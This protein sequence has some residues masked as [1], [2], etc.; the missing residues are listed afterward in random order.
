MRP[1]H[2]LPTRSAIYKTRQAGPVQ[3]GSTGCDGDEQYYEYHGGVDKALLHYDQSHYAPW[4]SELPGSAHLFNVGGFGENFVSEGYD[5][6][7]VCIG[8]VVNVGREVVVQVSEPRQPCYK[9][10]HRF[11]VKDMSR[12]AQST[13]RTGWYYRVLREGSVQE[14]DE[15]VLV[16]RKH[17]KWS[18]SMVQHFLYADP[19]NAEALQELSELEELGEETRGIFA[20]RLRKQYLDE[21][22]RLVGGE[23]MILSSWKQYRVT[24]LK[25][26]TPRILSLTCSLADSDQDANSSTEESNTAETNGRPIPPGSHIRLKLASGLTR[27]YSIISGTS[28][29]L[30][31]AIALAEKATD[32]TVSVSA[33]IHQT[34]RENDTLILSRPVRS[35]P[36]SADASHHILLAAGIGITAM[37]AAAHTLQQ[38]GKS[39]A[40]HYAVRSPA[41]IGFSRELAAL[42]HKTIYPAS[43]G[44][45]LNVPAILRSRKPNSHIYTCGPPR[46]TAAVVAAA[47]EV[48]IPGKELHF[49][50]FATEKSGEPF[51]AECAVSKQT[52]RVG[53]QES[54]FDVLRKAG[55]D[56]NSSCEVG[57][58]GTCWVGVRGGEVERRGAADMSAGIGDGKGMLSCVDRGVGKLVLEL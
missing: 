56:V 27:P 10:N 4:R 6:G 53:G 32:P 42:D 15:I 7:N 2:N 19:H 3:V 34:L 20:N 26:E 57:N 55:L 22:Q 18:I 54:L 1:F 12:R 31:F 58:C 14:G 52:L 17:P 45:R 39:Y 37:L 13:G 16:E 49:E 30:T 28:S 48:G 8:D 36:P 44:E 24:A 43:S 35:F 11:E 29:L 50:A 21:E 5:E 46:L 23:E 25:R 38:E 9:L 33:Y 41:D 47:K 51:E 40:L